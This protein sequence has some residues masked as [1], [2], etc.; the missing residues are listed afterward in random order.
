MDSGDLLGVAILTKSEDDVQRMI[1]KPGFRRHSLNQVLGSGGHTPLALATSA[2]RLGMVKLLIDAGADPLAYCDGDNCIHVAARVRGVPF[3]S[4]TNSVVETESRFLRTVASRGTRGAPSTH[5]CTSTVR[6]V[7][8]HTPISH[9][10]ERFSK[11]YFSAR[12]TVKVREN[13][14]VGRK[15]R[16]V[17]SF[18]QKVG[19]I[20]FFGILIVV[21]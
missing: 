14:G 13:V 11:L 7:R 8:Y 6:C 3:I 9:S 20:F 2:G 5:G 21:E 15:N 17:K 12:K 10:L 19:T 4:N 16:P 18:P 1:G